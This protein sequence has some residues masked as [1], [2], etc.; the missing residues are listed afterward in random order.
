MRQTL[1]GRALN[2]RHES[3]GSALVETS[4]ALILAFPAILSAFELCMFTYTQAILGDAA[5]VGTRYAIVH[6]TDSTLCSGPSTGCAD[7]TAANVI[8]TVTNY[9]T[10]SLS[11]LR[12]ISVTPSYLDSSSAPPSRVTVTVTYTYTPLFNSSVLSIPM[13]ATAEGRIV[14]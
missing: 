6:G 7:S 10:D 11:S 8:S 1:I 9:A 4:L 12:S 13:Y 2:L 14:Y 3:L 5:R